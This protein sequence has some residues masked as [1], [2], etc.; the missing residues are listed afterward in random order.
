MKNLCNC[1]NY[2]RPEQLQIHRVDCIDILNSIRAEKEYNSADDN[3]EID[4]EVNEEAEDQLI[5]P[6]STAKK[7][8]NNIELILR[9]YEANISTEK[10]SNFCLFYSRRY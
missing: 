7:A 10:I 4:H 8:M 9:F 5:E 2:S 6:I 3:K 1:K